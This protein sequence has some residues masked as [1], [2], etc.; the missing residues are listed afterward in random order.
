MNPEYTISNKI[1]M[2]E[3]SPDFGFFQNNMVLLNNVNER[4]LIKDQPTPTNP[5]HPPKPKHFI[6]QRNVT[7]FRYFS[8]INLNNSAPNLLIINPLPKPSIPQPPPTEEPKEEVFCKVC[9]ESASTE[10]TGKLIAPCLCSGSVKYIH[11][12]CLKTWLVSQN[13]DLKLAS[14]ELCHLFY[15]MEIR[16]GLKFFPQE[17]C[18]HGLQNA[19]AVVC[20]VIFLGCLVVII[21]MFS[22]QWYEI[23]NCC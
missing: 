18:R 8:K 17:A 14:C 5:S 13:A 19:L 20:L 22:L 6:N 1:V 12:E 15:K 2:M 9:F 10:A 3:D 21:I 11:E 23:K 7:T 4:Y 16:L